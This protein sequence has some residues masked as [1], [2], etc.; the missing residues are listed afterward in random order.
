MDGESETWREWERETGGWRCGFIRQLRLCGG[1][2]VGPLGSVCWGDGGLHGSD[3]FQHVPQTL[4]RIAIWGILRPGR[5][6]QLFVTFLKLF[7]SLEGTFHCNK[8][9]SCRWFE[10][11]G[12][13]VYEAFNIQVS[14][15]HWGSPTADHTELRAY[16]VLMSRILTVLVCLLIIA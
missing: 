15:R 6:L 14:L 1:L 2:V 16:R 4:G 12:R 9:I 5:H 10:C 11:C 8:T 7:L 3:L 13:S